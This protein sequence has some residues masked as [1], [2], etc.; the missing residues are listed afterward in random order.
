MFKNKNKTT[1]IAGRLCHEPILY[2]G[3]FTNKGLLRLAWQ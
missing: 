2:Y 1:V 3:T